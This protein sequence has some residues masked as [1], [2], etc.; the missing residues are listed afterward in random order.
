MSTKLLFRPSE[1][2]DYEQ[3]VALLSN[4]FEVPTDAA[5]LRRPVMQWKYWDERPDWPERR[6]YVLQAGDR[7]VG[8]VGLWPGIVTRANEARR[9][10]HMIDWVGAPD[11]PGAGLVQVQRVARLFDFVYAIGGS[12]ATRGVLPAF[13]FKE[14]KTAITVA[15]PLRPMVM[16]KADI[17]H[18]WKLPARTARNLFW[19][20]VPRTTPAAEAWECESTV[21]AGPV[22]SS[23]SIDRDTAFFDYLSRC[24]AAVFRHFRLRQHGRDRGYMSLAM[25][26]GQARL[27]GYW[28]N[29]PTP[30]D[31]EAVFILAQRAAVALQGCELSCI[32][33]NEAAAA[34][35]ARAGLRTRATKPV[36]L[37]DRQGA[38]GQPADV[39]FHMSDFDAAFLDD[40]TA[41]YLCQ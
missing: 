30:G 3:I 9:G 6:G 16:L 33:S 37:Y 19:S 7:L 35:A 25:V 21:L 8:H 41:D 39:T 2:A 22:S 26:R 23:A 29:Q 32:V 40:G 36:Y 14:I 15:R 38:L 4:V 1:P 31:E 13:G 10:V 17:S 20:M 24:P 12:P 27:A 28:L 5:F 11:V 34:A 18:D